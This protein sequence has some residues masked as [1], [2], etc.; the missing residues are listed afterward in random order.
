MDI[1]NKEIKALVGNSFVMDCYEICLVQQ[2]N[3]NPITFKGPGSIYQDEEGVL[4]LKMYYMN[5][6]DENI[7]RNVGYTDSGKVI[8]NDKYFHLKARDM[9]GGI[10]EAK[11]V[12]DVGDTYPSGKVIKTK[13]QSIEC[14]IEKK[15]ESEKFLVLLIPG[16]QKIPANKY[17][18]HDEGRTLNRCEL[19]INDIKGSIEKKQGYLEVVF[20]KSESIPEEF[21]KRILQ[22]LNIIFGKI[23]F[24][25]FS[26]IDVGK[27]S[28]KKII[29]LQPD[30]PNNK[31]MGFIRYDEPF[32]AE[33]FQNFITCYV[34]FFEE[35][36]HE[37][38][39]YWHKINR[40]WQGGF[41]NMALSLSVAIEG[42]VKE[43]FKELGYTDPTLLEEAEIAKKIIQQR[44]QFRKIKEILVGRLGN[45]KQSD[46]KT[47]LYTLSNNDVFPKDFISQ[48]K[49]LRHSSA[50]ADKL[51]ES[52]QDIQ[53]FVNQVWSCITLF[54]ILLMHKI[55]YQGKFSGW[56]GEEWED[57]L[58]FP[59][60]CDTENS[61]SF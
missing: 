44:C 43:Y 31:V 12:Q 32:Y 2:V 42:V 34:N 13:L 23:N 21:E 41:E 33:D 4:N 60:V 1:G 55:D 15:T 10:W 51:D 36:D 17:T 28:T 61:V 39:G 48:W 25:V 45:L 7:Y 27:I 24:P 8:S 22:A 52:P 16:D 3:E 53:K 19:L 50:H 54:N 11:N 6:G 29:T 5:D 40:A 59:I 57:E 20:K 46:A 35:G 30:T 37:F 38:Y 26:K 49:K 58:I 14:V 18:N 47:S 9:A 56:S